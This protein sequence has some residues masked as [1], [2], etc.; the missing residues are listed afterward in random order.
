MID[1]RLIRSDRRTLS[2]SIDRE[3]ALVVRAPKRVNK[4]D[5][6]AFIQQKERWILEKQAA[7][8][9]RIAARPKLA[10]GA[11]VP[12]WGSTLIIAFGDVKKAVRKD[13]ILWLPKTGEAARHARKWRMEQ[14]GTLL[15]PRVEYWAAQ[16]GL[17]P[18]KIAFGNAQTRWGSMN[19]QTRSL[20]LNAALIHC[21]QDI[22]D[23]VVVH[24]LVH[25]IH[26]N[27][28]PAFHAAVRRIL[29]DA[30][31]RRAALKGYTGLIRLWE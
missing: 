14:A 4:R 26:P 30:D 22:V 9:Q 11:A 3:G 19:T 5:I 25:I 6:E 28:S 7:A 20:R 21:P 1:Y 12:F 2:I 27:H 13:G 17:Q 24:E 29:P 23:Y 10:D 16:T 18:V 8:K 31:G 15:T